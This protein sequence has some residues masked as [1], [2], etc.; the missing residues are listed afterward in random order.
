M[1]AAKAFVIEN[2]QYSTW[3]KIINF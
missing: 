1:Y 2:P 3:L